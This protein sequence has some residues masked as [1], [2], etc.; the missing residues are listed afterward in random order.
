MSYKRMDQLKEG[1]FI[2]ITDRGWYKSYYRAGAKIFKDVP[3]E[4]R[5]L[6]YIQED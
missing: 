2:I 5:I 6:G 4:D 3:N 1:W